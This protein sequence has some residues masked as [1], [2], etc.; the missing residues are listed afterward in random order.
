MLK[1]GSSKRICKTRRK[2][3]KYDIFFKIK[4]CFVHSQYQKK[5]GLLAFK[6]ATV[7]VSK[8]KTCVSFGFDRYFAD[9]LWKVSSLIFELL[10]AL[11]KSQVIIISPLN[12][13]IEEQVSKFGTD[14]TCIDTKLRPRCLSN[15]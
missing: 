14:F 10:P 15:A 5:F 11:N 2:E 9:G 6:T 3:F 13:I 8:P 12:A 7:T 4:N 1:N